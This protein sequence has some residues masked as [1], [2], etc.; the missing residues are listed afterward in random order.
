MN[1]IDFFYK[2][3]NEMNIYL[4]EH[5]NYIKNI[6]NSKIYIPSP[7]SSPR[8][9]ESIRYEIY[10]FHDDIPNLY[11]DDDDVNYVKV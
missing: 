10:N 1:I 11:F 4:N 2:V 8:Y 3:S 6:Y 7:P 9:K 5:F